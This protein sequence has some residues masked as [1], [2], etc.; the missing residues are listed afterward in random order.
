VEI[1]VVDSDFEGFSSEVI[2]DGLG[3]L[4][5]NLPGESDNNLVVS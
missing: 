2:L 4:T 5:W 3:Y 1:S